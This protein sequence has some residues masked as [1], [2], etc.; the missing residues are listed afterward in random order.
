MIRRYIVR[1]DNHACGEWL[2]RVIDRDTLPAAA[3]GQ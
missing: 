3:S 1:R 2:Y